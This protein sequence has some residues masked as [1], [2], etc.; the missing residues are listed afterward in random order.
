MNYYANKACWKG[1]FQM[2]L[3]YFV[4]LKGYRQSGH[5]RLLTPNPIFLQGDWE[6]GKAL[7]RENVII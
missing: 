7:N 3:F 4:N 5:L 6:A 1:P 2:G